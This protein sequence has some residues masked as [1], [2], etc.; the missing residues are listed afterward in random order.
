MEQLED[1]SR[2]IRSKEN[3]IEDLNQKILDLEEQN[4][5]IHASVQAQKEAAAA[6]SANKGIEMLMNSNM[7][8]K[9]MSDPRFLK[10][11][12]NK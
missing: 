7:K 6:E 2:I 9:M 1:L 11:M 8:D 5:K 10:M 12:Q 4:R 3:E